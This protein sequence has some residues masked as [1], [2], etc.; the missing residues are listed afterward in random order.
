MSTTQLLQQILSV[1]GELN[2]YVQR[3]NELKDFLNIAAE[4]HDQ[5]TGLARG[6][7]NVPDLQVE[8]GPRIPTR[9]HAQAIL[10][11]LSAL[12]PVST[13][14]DL[15]TRLGIGKLLAN[16]VQGVTYSLYSEFSDLIP[17]GNGPN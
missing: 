7:L 13:D 9:A 11:I 16:L 8:K 3:E 4:L 14:I 10:D 12:P 5:A 6:A 1:F 15:A 2:A 17:R